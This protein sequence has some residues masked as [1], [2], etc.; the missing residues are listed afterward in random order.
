MFTCYWMNYTKPDNRFIS[1][2]NP[3]VYHWWEGLRRLPWEQQQDL[4][5]HS[6]QEKGL[7]DR[8]SAGK[9]FASP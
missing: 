9:S 5:P 3:S 1:V 8:N 4:H 6:Q 7:Q 2:P